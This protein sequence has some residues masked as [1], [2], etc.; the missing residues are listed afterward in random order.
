MD[1]LD[2]GWKSLFLVGVLCTLISPYIGRIS[3][4]LESKLIGME[5]SAVCESAD[6]YSAS[7]SLPSPDSAGQTAYTS[8]ECSLGQTNHAETEIDETQCLSRVLSASLQDT[9]EAES[10]IP[11][12]HDSDPEVEPE[13]GGDLIDPKQQTEYTAQ[14]AATLGMPSADSTGVNN[15]SSGNGISDQED[16]DFDAVLDELLPSSKQTAVKVIPEIAA[17]GPGVN[18]SQPLWLQLAAQSTTGSQAVAGI[19]PPTVPVSLQAGLAQL[20][21]EDAYLWARVMQ[22]DSTA[23]LLSKPQPPLS[24]AYSVM[25]SAVRRSS[26]HILVSSY[27][28]GQPVAPGA[29]LLQ[30]VLAGAAAPASTVPEVPAEKAADRLTGAALL[31][32]LRRCGA[33]D[34]A[35]RPFVPPGTPVVEG[36]R[37]IAE[38]LPQQMLQETCSRVVLPMLSGSAEKHL[39][40]AAMLQ[41]H[42]PGVSAL[43]TLLRPAADSSGTIGH[44]L[45]PDDDTMLNDAFDF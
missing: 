12:C 32:A 21:Q 43:Q 33:A 20:P 22:R 13:H 38:S 29:S 17:R 1:E 10:D 37:I 24:N 39:G 16:F 11:A 35:G 23:Q 30:H 44:D 3:A 27:M 45:G 26:S 9:A 31:F 18:P 28:A 4:F 25:Q 2:A 34:E 14:H 40:I 15:N 7:E 8:A 41:T 19:P 36:A 6:I 42:E 5:T